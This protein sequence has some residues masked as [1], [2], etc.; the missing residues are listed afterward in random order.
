M[1]NDQIL[2]HGPFEISLIPNFSS[3]PCPSPP[4]RGE[5]ICEPVTM[6]YL[7]GKYF[8]LSHSCLW[9]TLYPYYIC[10]IWKKCVALNNSE[11]YV[12]GNR[13]HFVLCVLPATPYYLISKHVYFFEKWVMSPP[14]TNGSFGL[15]VTKINRKFF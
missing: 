11:R 6:V 13:Y 14:Q 5:P 3:K 12:F 10:Q 7:L 2:Y 8:Y 9:R 1:Y 4:N 15:S